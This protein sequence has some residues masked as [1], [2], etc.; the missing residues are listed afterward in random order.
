MEMA[1]LSK[2]EGGRAACRIISLKSTPW[3]TN[4]V[5]EREEENFASHSDNYVI[6]AKSVTVTPLTVTVG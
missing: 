5:E 2:R 1:S 4:H 3:R 6:Q